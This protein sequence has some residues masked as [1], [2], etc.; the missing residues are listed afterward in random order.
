M[1]V[2]AVISLDVP[3][4]AMNGLSSRVPQGRYSMLTTQVREVALLSYLPATSRCRAASMPTVYVVI[5]KVV[6]VVAF[7]LRSIPSRVLPP[8]QSQRMAPINATIVQPT[9]SIPL[10]PVDVSVS[11]PKIHPLTVVSSV[12]RVAVA[13]SR[14]LAQSLFKILCKPM[15]T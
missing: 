7:I 13:I 5:D 9:V 4:A 2:T 1:G 3:M 6:R 11:I 8:V 10:A 15:V 12:R 14:A